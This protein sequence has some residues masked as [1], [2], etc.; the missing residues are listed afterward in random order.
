MRISIPMTPDLENYIDT[1]G[2]REHHALA[3]CRVEAQT[4]GQMAVMQIA[5]EQGAL[6][7]LFV[8]LIDARRILE[9]GTFTGYSALA[10][11][12]SLPDDGRVITVD[13]DTKT[14]EVAQNFWRAA[15][16]EHKIDARIADGLDAMDDL[17][18]GGSSFDI[19]LIDADK[20]G[21]PAYIDRAIELVRVGGLIIVDD[22]LIHGRVATG[23]LAGDPDF[24]A[25]AVD[26]MRDVNQRLHGDDRLTIAMIPAHDGLTLARRRR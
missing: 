7:Q 9:I 13:C 22:T 3:A 20:P 21:Y 8:E 16:V 25:P 18:S 26:A 2:Y 15:A 24:V 1:V 10:L 23:P 6:L 12:L 14:G 5:P 19:V 4:R 17:I 11:A